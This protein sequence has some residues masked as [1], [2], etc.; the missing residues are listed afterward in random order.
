MRASVP[1]GKRAGVCSS[2]I[3]GLPTDGRISDIIFSV[4]V[5]PFL[6]SPIDCI[7]DI[8]YECNQISDWSNQMARIKYFA[9]TA[10]GTLAWV[11][12]QRGVRHD[13]GRSFSGFDATSGQWVK[14]TRVVEMRANPSRHECDDRCINATGRVMKCE[15]ACGGKNHGRG[16]PVC[17]VAV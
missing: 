6:I 11:D 14:V 3:F 7:H 1:A 4:N 8:M 5:A 16:A 13:G 17:E 2:L 9:D 12:G 10:T 15:C